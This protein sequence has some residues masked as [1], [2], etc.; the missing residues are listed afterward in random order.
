[1]VVGDIAKNARHAEMWRKLQREAA[2]RPESKLVET[3]GGTIWMSPIEATL[4]AAMVKEGLQPTPQ[5][6]VEGYFVDFAFPDVRY[7]VE[8]DGA[9]F[10][11]GEA[12]RRDQRRDWILKNAGWKVQRFHGSTIH[13]RPDN[14]A[15]VV[16]R[17]VEGIRSA[18]RERA[19]AV[20]AAKERKRQARRAMFAKVFGIFRRRKQG[21]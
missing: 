21:P 11:G 15:F 12:K 2:A 16:K 14:C 4:Y 9:A 5:F 18:V 13:D 6:C 3:P 7:A 17:D 8:A 1:M 20:A 19:A 10:H